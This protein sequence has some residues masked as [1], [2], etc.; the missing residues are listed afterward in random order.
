MKHRVIMSAAEAARTHACRRAFQRH[1]LAMAL[2]DVVKIERKIWMGNAT[3][4]SDEPRM[5][6][7]YEVLYR[8]RK[9]RVI[10][11]IHIAAIVTI[12]PKIDM[13]PA[14]RRAA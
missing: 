12:L 11:D 2:P 5:R 1:G 13:R 8:R 7:T 10:F 4:L 9:L 14:R 3:W 6:S